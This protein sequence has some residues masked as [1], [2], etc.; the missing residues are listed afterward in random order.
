[1]MNFRLTFLILCLSIFAGTQNYAQSQEDIDTSLLIEN[2]VIQQNRL[3]LPLTEQSRF[4][5]VIDKEEI[6]S[7]PVNNIPELLQFTGAVD[8]RRRGVNG[9]QSDAGIRGSTFNQILVLINGVR[10]SD[11]QTGHH[12]MNLPVALEDIKR[13]EIIKG[14]AARIFG[15]NAMVIPRLLFDLEENIAREVIPGGK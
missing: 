9:V 7:L 12:M 5:E 6:Q 8:I 15:M 4:I 14:P 13:I 11:P 1:M 10:M 2:V 3:N